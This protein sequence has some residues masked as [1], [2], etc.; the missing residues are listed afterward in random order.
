MSPSHQERRLESGNQRGTA[1][2][3]GAEWRRCARG[4][5]ALR[6]PR[7]PHIITPILASLGLVRKTHLYLSNQLESGHGSTKAPILLSSEQSDEPSWQPKRR[8]HV[9]LPQPSPYLASSH[10][11]ES[12]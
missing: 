8:G 6:R 11:L 2:K 1:G 12:V 4:R 5:T 3:M 7:L 9:V 10:R